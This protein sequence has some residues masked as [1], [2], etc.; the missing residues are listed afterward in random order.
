MECHL[1][2][3][4]LDR[5]NRLEPDDDATTDQ[6]REA[7]SQIE[8]YLHASPEEAFGI[9][10][11]SACLLHL[12]RLC[13]VFDNPEEFEEP[14]EPICIRLDDSDQEISSNSFV[15]VEGGGEQ[16]QF[17]FQRKRWTMIE[18]GATC[19]DYSMRGG[20]AQ[21]IGKS[22]KPFLI[23]SPSCAIKNPF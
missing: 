6:K 4:G 22:V 3:K 10:V 14:V 17:L 13:P 7:Y 15:Q 19:T 12:G 11:S 8:A 21:N 5:I 2:P 20:L 9:C 18:A 16:Q 23:L 1:T